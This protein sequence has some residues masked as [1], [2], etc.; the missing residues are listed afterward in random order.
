[1]DA[2]P[3]DVCAHLLL[4]GSEYVDNQLKQVGGVFN[5]RCAGLVLTLN[6]R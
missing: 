1:M 4:K 3:V 5:L 2:R 6:V